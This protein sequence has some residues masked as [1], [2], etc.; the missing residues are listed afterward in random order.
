MTPENA[1]L[2]IGEALVFNASVADG[3]APYVYQWFLNGEAVAGATGQ[4]W[5]F[6]P[7]A[8]GTYSVYVQV[9]DSLGAKGQSGTSV[10]TCEVIDDS[11][12]GDVNWNVIVIVLAASIVIVVLLVFGRRIVSS[13]KKVNSKRALS[14]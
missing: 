3:H 4:S 5:D 9:V 12:E 8:T 1:N 13:G 10:I 2:T 11:S 7:N 6:K 14:T